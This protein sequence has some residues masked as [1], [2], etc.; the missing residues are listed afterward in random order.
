MELEV[1]IN[2]YS[3]A[4]DRTVTESGSFKVCFAKSRIHSW[5]NSY[6]LNC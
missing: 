2:R 3:S 6:L 5:N 4:F 1:F